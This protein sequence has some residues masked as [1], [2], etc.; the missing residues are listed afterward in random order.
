MRVEGD[1]ER[2]VRH[3]R[4][5][6]LLWNVGLETSERIVE[7]GVDALVA[8]VEAPTL[9]LLAGLTRQEAATEASELARQVLDELGVSLPPIASTAPKVA[10]AG[11]LAEMALAGE[12]RP[13]AV[14]FTI[15]KLLFSDAL[16]LALPFMHLNEE[17]ALAGDQANPAA[18]F[19]AID[20]GVLSEAQ[21]LL[22]RV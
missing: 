17:Y 15:E 12:R 20:N 8:G 1:G 21:T 5:A 22:N 9:P 11:A 7:T 6:A 10:A 14:S 18:A 3:L 16:D 4:E 2:V 13:S 19:E